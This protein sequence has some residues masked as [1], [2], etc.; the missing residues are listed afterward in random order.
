VTADAS[1]SNLNIDSDKASP[2][3]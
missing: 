3:R 2:S 1:A